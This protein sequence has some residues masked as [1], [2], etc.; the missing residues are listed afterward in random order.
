[1]FKAHKQESP[2]TGRSR[3]YEQFPAPFDPNKNGFDFH[4]KLTPTANRADALKFTPPVYYMPSN[5]S[6]VKFARQL[7]ENIKKEFPEVKSHYWSVLYLKLILACV[8]SDWQ[9]LG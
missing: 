3:A 1:M 6:E 8:A 2:V 4:G 5:E 7:Y 9:V